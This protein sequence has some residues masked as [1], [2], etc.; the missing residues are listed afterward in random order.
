MRLA[1]SLAVLVILASP[2]EARHRHHGHCPPGQIWMRHD[3]ECVAKPHRRHYT[4]IPAEAVPMPPR[5]IDATPDPWQSPPPS[6]DVGVP[7]GSG[8]GKHAGRWWY[9]P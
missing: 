3:R 2:A 7:I 1:L 4:A 8:M 9:V 6:I 5:R